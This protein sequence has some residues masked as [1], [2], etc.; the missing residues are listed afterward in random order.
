MYPLLPALLFFK[1]MRVKSQRLFLIHKAIKYYQ[2]DLIRLLDYGTLKLEKVY[3]FY[4]DIRTKY[5]HAC[6]IIKATQLL[7]VQ[8]I[9]LVKYGGIL[10]CIK[11]RNDLKT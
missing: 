1:D 6:L 2:Q 8:K 7:Q 4:R 11:R 10:K 9:I 5:S 3:K